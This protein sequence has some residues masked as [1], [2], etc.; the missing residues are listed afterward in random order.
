[1]RKATAATHKA[2]ARKGRAR[3]RGGE[4]R[5]RTLEDRMLAIE[6]LV[7]RQD[8]SFARLVAP[9][10][11]IAARVEVVEQHLERQDRRLDV[12]YRGFDK[13]LKQFSPG[14]GG[15]AAVEAEVA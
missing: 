14:G 11:G 7:K 12:I 9:V 15:M 13:V 6:T 2:A 8:K 3:R 10:V 4:S 1:M 5:L